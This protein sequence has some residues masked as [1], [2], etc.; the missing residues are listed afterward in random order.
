MTSPYDSFAWFYD[1]YWAEPFHRWNLLALDRLLFPNLRPGCT[2]VDLCCGTGQLANSLIEHGYRVTGIDGS[3]E[4][5]RYAKRNA[6]GASFLQS[7]AA[8]FICAAPVDAVVSCFDSFN[9]ILDPARIQKLFGKARAA[10]NPDGL[11]VFDVNTSEA[12]GEAW[13]RS[14]C[15]V[16]PDDAFFL[17]GEFDTGTRRAVTCITMFRLTDSW[18][19]SDIEVWQRPW[20]I[21]EIRHMLE[22]AGFTRIEHFRTLQDFGIAGHYGTGRVYFRACSAASSLHS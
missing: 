20:D 13:N 7:D 9:H 15:E 21:P 10:L 5:L 14:A 12:Y 17:R 8:E 18:Q 11:F 3:A 4:M 19:R 6:P 2:I 1:R 16:H 22:S